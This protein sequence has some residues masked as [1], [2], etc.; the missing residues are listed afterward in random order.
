MMR[1]MQ[2]I[3]TVLTIVLVITSQLVAQ[4]NAAYPETRK[5]EHVDEYHG[6]QVPDPYRWLEEDVRTS[7]EVADWVEAQ[8]K[9]T[10]GFLESIPQRDTIRKRLTELWDYEKYGSPFKAG[11]GII[12]CTIRVCRISSSFFHHG[13]ARQPAACADGS[14]PVVGGWYGRLG[15]NGFQR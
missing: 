12:I 11:G 9:V 8:N 10:F 13:D 15:R 4:G 5:V 3:S 1:A 2:L 14:Q 7:E 6:T